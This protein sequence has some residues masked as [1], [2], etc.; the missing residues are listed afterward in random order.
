VSDQNPTVRPLPPYRSR[1]ESAD[2]PV[3]VRTQDRLA[4]EQ[5]LR[6]VAEAERL[7]LEK[8]TIAL[9]EQLARKAIQRSAPPAP[10]S[11]PGKPQHHWTAILGP[12]GAATALVI[13]IA[14]GFQGPSKGEFEA[15]KSTVREV[16]E[17]REKEKKEAAQREEA[18]QKYAKDV[19]NWQ[20]ALYDRL[21]VRVRRPEGFEEPEPIEASAPRRA[22]LKR[23]A[24]TE[25]PPIEILT[26][27]PTPP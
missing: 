11:T 18:W 5:A 23:G 25:W 20:L 12:G 27:P 17:A 15:L 1:Q 8:K 16:S 13:A 22:P 14:S 10:P 3:T 2:D 4:T 21:G 24:A 26:A 7:A 19:T 6:R 9:E